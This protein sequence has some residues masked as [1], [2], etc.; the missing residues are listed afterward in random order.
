MAMIDDN[1][2]FLLDLECP[3]KCGYCCNEW[4]DLVAFGHFAN[5][6]LWGGHCPNLGQTGCKLPRRKRPIE[7]TAYLCELAILAGQGK[8]DVDQIKRVVDAK[9]QHSAFAY[10]GVWSTIDLDIQAERAKI[11]PDDKRKIDKLF[12]K[13]RS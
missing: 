4:K 12:R 11:R 1:G 10:L 9:R 2:N 5:E 6:I 13:R 7:C 3:V 8:V